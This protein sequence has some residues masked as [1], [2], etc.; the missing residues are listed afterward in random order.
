M[1]DSMLGGGGLGRVTATT[2]DSHPPRKRDDRSGK[3]REPEDARDQDAGGGERESDGPGFMAPILDLSTARKRAEDLEILL[4]AEAGDSG[5]RRLAVVE[6]LLSVYHLI[7]G[8]MAARGDADAVA[9]SGRKAEVAASRAPEAASEARQDID[10]LT[11]G[12]SEWDEAFSSLRRQVTSVT[13]KIRAVSAEA[14]RAAQETAHQGIAME[15]RSVA[16]D[17]T[18][19]GIALE[20]AVKGGGPVATYGRNGVASTVPEPQSGGPKVLSTEV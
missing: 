8:M 10:R 1:T 4:E 12:G 18:E 5:R 20:R 3:E 9:E 16:H 19:I 17:L 11:G 7:V 13:L 2:P 14:A 15:L 6:D